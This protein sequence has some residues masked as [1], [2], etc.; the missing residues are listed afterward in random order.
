MADNTEPRMHTL[1]FESP[2]E[3]IEDLRMLT[4]RL[5]SVVRA[6]QLSR[7]QIIILL[8]GLP[9]ID[10]KKL[11]ELGEKDNFCPIC[12]VPFLTILTEEEMASAMDSPAHPVEES[13]ITK[14]SHS[15]QCGHMFCRK[16][17]SKWILS[18]HASCPMCR[19]DLAENESSEQQ[20]TEQQIAD[21]DRDME[22]FESATNIIRRQIASL[23]PLLNSID[24]P[25]FD[26]LMGPHLARALE[27][28]ANGEDR[29]DFSGMYS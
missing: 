18:G 16:D 25:A 26:D 20:A 1:T 19:R 22:E 12:F 21:A 14:L 10:E 9:R 4:E 29:H 8:D 24:G 13:G 27:T 6:G 5:R 15:W 28:N 17:I 7:E 3:L 23:R 2:D 11:S